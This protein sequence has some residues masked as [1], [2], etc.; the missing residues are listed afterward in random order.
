M[1][2]VTPGGTVEVEKGRKKRA[3]EGK[4]S[5]GSGRDEGKGRK[6]GAH[7][8]DSLSNMGEVKK[9]QRREILSRKTYKTK[10]EDARKE[11]SAFLAPEKGVKE[12]ETNRTKNPR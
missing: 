11:G 5:S 10:A 7:D 4:V 12:R 9:T 6:A 3:K 1:V 2:P 8:G